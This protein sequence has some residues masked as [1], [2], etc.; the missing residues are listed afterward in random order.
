MRTIANT[1]D[2]LLDTALLPLVAIAQAYHQ[3]R[4][5]DICGTPP[6]STEIFSGRG[7]ACLL[8]IADALAGA[9]AA[10]RGDEAAKIAALEPLARI[11]QRYDA[12]ELDDE[13]RRFWG[14][15]LEH[16][17]T[18]PP[19]DIELV[20]TRGGAPL[21]TLADALVAREAL[22]IKIGQPA[23]ASAITVLA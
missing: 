15:D 9:E 4:I 16:E 5:D 22:D 19:Q 21:L 7:G 8:T 14:Q 13:A 17:N 20:T 6:E 11:A 12:N 3:D 10:K 2:Q 18:T 23:Q 1:I